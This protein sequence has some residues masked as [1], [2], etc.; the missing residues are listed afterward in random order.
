MEAGG[1]ES[2]S[3]PSLT[4]RLPGAALRVA[5]V[6]GSGDHVGLISAV[7]FGHSSEGREQ[8]CQAGTAPEVRVGRMVCSQV[9]GRRGGPRK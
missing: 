5:G 4:G 3:A 7:C 9:P 2:P 6:S 8:V 1:R